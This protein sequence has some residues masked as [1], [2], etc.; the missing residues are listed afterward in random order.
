[1]LFHG[2]E[3]EFA[4]P[5]VFGACAAFQVVIKSCKYLL[6]ALDLHTETAEDD[7]DRDIRIGI[8]SRID[9]KTSKKTCKHTHRTHA[10]NQEGVET[11]K[12]T[13]GWNRMNSA[14]RRNVACD[15]FFSTADGETDAVLLGGFVP[16]RNAVSMFVLHSVCFHLSSRTSS[17][18]TSSQHFGPFS[19]E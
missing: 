8:R 14:F 6:F 13:V 11:R 15:Q 12:P 5:N 7:R 3:M 16:S 10:E 4:L 9:R 1:M 17:I 19:R 2:H 18:G